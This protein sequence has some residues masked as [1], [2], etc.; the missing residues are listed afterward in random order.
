VTLVDQS[1]Y[2]S[3]QASYQLDTATPI[4][5]QR[6]GVRLCERP[7]ARA[8]A[9]EAMGSKLSENPLTGAAS[10]QPC[11]FSGTQR[12]TRRGANPP[13]QRPTLAEVMRTMSR[14]P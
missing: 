13:L 2:R 12:L 6:G 9:K 7:L 8:E 5:A 11:A 4:Y 1:P 14:Q 10:G 3:A